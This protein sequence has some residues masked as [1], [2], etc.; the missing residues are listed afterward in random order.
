M[1]PRRFADNDSFGAA[2]PY[3]AGTDDRRK[4]LVKVFKHLFFFVTDAELK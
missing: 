3:S 1:P 4:N 2:L